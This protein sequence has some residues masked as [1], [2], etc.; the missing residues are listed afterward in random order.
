MCALHYGSTVQT[1]CSHFSVKISVMKYQSVSYIFEISGQFAW[2]LAMW[3][4]PRRPGVANASAKRSWKEIGPNHIKSSKRLLSLIDL[5][6][7]DNK[8]CKQL[9]VTSF[10]ILVP[11]LIHH[12]SFSF[13]RRQCSGAYD[14]LRHGANPAAKRWFFEAEKRKMQLDLWTKRD[15][16]PQR[17]HD[18]ESGRHMNFS[19]SLLDRRW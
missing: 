18:Q 15:E 17:H 5:I 11:T 9:M 16:R 12:I 1:A 19:C 4:T 7:I 3:V 14:K 2:L 13:E 6:S 10:D 8:E